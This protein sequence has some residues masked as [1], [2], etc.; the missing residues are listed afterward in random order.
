MEPPFHKERCR[1][2]LRME[3]KHNGCCKPNIDN[4]RVDRI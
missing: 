2:G 3:K 4:L 1:K